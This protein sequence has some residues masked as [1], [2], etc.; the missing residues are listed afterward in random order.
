M[1]TTITMTSDSLS[2]THHSLC[3]TAVLHYR[4]DRSCS[5]LPRP[6][7][8]GL[9]FDKNLKQNSLM[10]SLIDMM[11]RVLLWLASENVAV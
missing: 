8:L 11:Q 7:R 1:M 2:G 10:A 9:V 5:G 4:D 3:N 6:I